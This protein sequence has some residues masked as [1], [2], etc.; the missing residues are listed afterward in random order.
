MA[1]KVEVISDKELR[2]RG[3][4]AW[5]VKKHLLG[6][7]KH[8]TETIQKLERIVEDNPKGDSITIDK[9]TVIEA[10]AAIE[11]LL[12]IEYHIQNEVL[13]QVKNA[14]TRKKLI[15]IDN[16]TRKIRQQISQTG[17]I[18]H[19][20]KK[21]NKTAIAKLSSAV[22]ELNQLSSDID[23]AARH[24][25]EQEQ[26]E[27]ETCVEDFGASKHK[28]GKIKKEKKKGFRLFGR[29]TPAQKR[30]KKAWETRRDKYG[31]SGHKKKSS[32]RK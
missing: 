26:I 24:L 8:T 31:D 6:G 23:F 13:P 20:V 15:A 30:A 25:M 18:F 21:V 14:S 32:K 10:E 9:S 29:K 7:R 27:C 22:G 5:C 2:D 11:D 16:K 3:N 12:Q 19:D 17:V 4:A 1:K 28:I